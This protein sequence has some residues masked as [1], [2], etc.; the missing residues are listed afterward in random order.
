[1]PFRFLEILG[2]GHGTLCA[3]LFIVGGHF[4]IVIICHFVHGQ[5]VVGAEADKSVFQSARGVGIGVH[6][7]PVDIGLYGCAFHLDGQMVERAG[8]FGFGE[9]LT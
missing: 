9:K 6:K 4:D 8:E 2:K 5:V 3:V 7:C 1:M